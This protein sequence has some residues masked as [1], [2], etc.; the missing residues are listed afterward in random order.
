MFLSICF[1]LIFTTTTTRRLDE[2][3][4]FDLF[5]VL[6][7]AFSCTSLIDKTTRNFDGPN[8]C[9][10]VR[11]WQTKSLSLWTINVQMHFK[12]VGLAVVC[13]RFDSNVLTSALVND[14]AVILYNCVRNEHRCIGTY[15]NGQRHLSEQALSHFDS[16]AFISIISFTRR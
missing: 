5:V 11:Q 1:S 2:L 16:C 13:E 12:S 10:H 3:S 14:I 7:S 4:Q 9:V 6:A 8:S 15:I